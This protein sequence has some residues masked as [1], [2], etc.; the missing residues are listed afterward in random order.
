MI[1]NNSYYL[2]VSGRKI[3]KYFSFYHNKTHFIKTK[4]EPDKQ[5]LKKNKLYGIL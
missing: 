2:V 1:I 5:A 4:K 3:I